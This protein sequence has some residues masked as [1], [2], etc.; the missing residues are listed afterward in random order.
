[1]TYFFLTKILNLSCQFFSDNPVISIAS[2]QNECESV[3]SFPNHCAVTEGHNV[4]FRCE[5]NSNPPPAVI[6]WSGS[7]Y[8][9]TKE[10]QLTSV[11]RQIGQ[12]RYICIVTTQSVADDK[13]LPLTSSRLLTVIIKCNFGLYFLSKNLEL[14][15]LSTSLPYVLSNSMFTSFL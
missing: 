7:I 3:P 13:R 12:S 4:T 1:M 5:V 11:N 14:L 15:Q 9:N 2:D 6:R 10:F 8:S